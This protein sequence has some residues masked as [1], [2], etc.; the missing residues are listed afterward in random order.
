MPRSPRASEIQTAVGIRLAASRSALG[1]TQEKIAEEIGVGQSTWAN[2]EGGTRLADPIA[3][4]RFCDAYN[5]TMDW[6]YR[7]QRG[8]LPHDLAEKIRQFYPRGIEPATKR[9]AVP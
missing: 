1:L 9:R 5:M 8:T 6:L 2:W 4:I 3:M 7:G